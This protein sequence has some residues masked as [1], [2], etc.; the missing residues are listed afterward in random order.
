MLTKL[1]YFHHNLSMRI[2][3]LKNQKS[4]SLRQFGREF[5][6]I[7]ITFIEYNPEGSDVEGEYVV[8]RNLFGEHHLQI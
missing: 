8:I 2:S 4:F 6:R 7:V 1:L 5:G 3:Y